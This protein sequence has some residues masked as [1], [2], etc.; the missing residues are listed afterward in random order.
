MCI[1]HRKQCVTCNEEGRQITVTEFS[2][3][4]AH[5]M[6]LTERGDGYVSRD[7]HVVSRPA[8]DRRVIVE[9]LV[10]ALPA[11]YDGEATIRVRRAEL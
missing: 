6:D 5:H 4:L 11:E 2:K 7:G 3:N 8:H 1:Y 10:G 9:S